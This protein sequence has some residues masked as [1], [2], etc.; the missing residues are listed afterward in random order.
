MKI[1]KRLKKLTKLKKYSKNVSLYFKDAKWSIFIVVIWFLIGAT[2][3]A[4][5]EPG[6]GITEI[7]LL[8]FYLKEPS[9]TETFVAFYRLV[10]T[11]II[12]QG[13]FAFI[14]SKS[15]EKYDPM[16]SSREIAKEIHEDH[17]VVVHYGHIGQRITDYLRQKKQKY[18]VI[19]QEKEAVKTLLDIGEPVIVGDPISDN[20]LL[21]AHVD[22]AHA[23]ILCTNDTKQALILSNKIR[24][25]NKNPDCRLIVRIFDDKLRKIL[26][27]P[28]YNAICFSTSK[29]TIENMKDKWIYAKKGK[30]IIIGVT[31]FT[32]RLIGELRAANREVLVIDDNEEDLDYFKGT[33]IKTFS[34]DPTQMSYLELPEIDIGSADQVFIGIKEEMSDS[35][36][37]SAS[38]KRLY[39]NVDVYVRLFDDNLAE[40]LER[41]DVKTFSTSKFTFTIL[42][43]KLLH[44]LIK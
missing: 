16:L 4:I 18:V 6:A 15:F 37:I 11:V 2:Y 10:G 41:L 32:I 7:I 36:S 20:V 42:E 27:K 29:T 44:Q 34:G 33:D 35:I 12:S 40:F 43:K 19:E 13:V 23:V 17:V 31:Y 26:E 24:H 22:K 21:D 9:Y 39:P 8:T 3:Y 38:I 1:K 14:I 28:P 30:A 5:R 25:F